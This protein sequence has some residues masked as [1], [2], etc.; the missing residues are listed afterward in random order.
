MFIQM[1]LLFRN[2]RSRNVRD[3]DLLD[4]CDVLQGGGFFQWLVARAHQ[5]E[6][7]LE[8]NV[9]HRFIQSSLIRLVGFD[10]VHSFIVDF[11]VKLEEA[12]D[13]HRDHLLRLSLHTEHLI[14]QLSILLVVLI[15]QD[16]EALR[17]ECV[18]KLLQEADLKGNGH[19][20]QLD[21]LFKI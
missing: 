12:H 6:A 18:V 13:C 15:L 20:I 11:R 16:C 7:F 5:F 1:T 9:K 10:E 14:C 2:N 17:F 21:I 8:L 4:I 19:P 3:L